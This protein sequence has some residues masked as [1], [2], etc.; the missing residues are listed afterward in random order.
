MPFFM[1]SV[2]TA[3]VLAQTRVIGPSPDTG[4]VYGNYIR[5][6]H[7]KG[8]RTLDHVLIRDVSKTCSGDCLN[9][10]DSSGPVTV[11]GGIWRQAGSPEKIGAI[12]SNI[13]GTLIVDGVTAIGSYDPK[14]Q[15][16]TKFPNKDGIMS[17]QRTFL[18]VNGGRFK[19]FWDAGID[20]KANTTMTGTVTVE[21]SRVSL[22][23]WGP[24]V[25]DTLISRNPRDGH[26]ACL[27]SPV[28]T[29]GIHLRKLVAYDSNPKGLLI[30]FQGS[31]GVVRIDEC[32]LHV[33]ATY[34]V[35]WIKRGSK[36]TKLILGPT[37]A[38]GDKIIVTQPVP[39]APPSARIVD[40]G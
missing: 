38:K 7:S 22:K 27:K 1:P 30:G 29:C 2:L 16:K 28:V 39:T 9:I 32:E 24:L 3:P 20:T 25:G 10:E 6:P 13:N 19:S 8:S 15:P 12:F 4:K 5:A 18:I 11:K 21:N 40:A 37:C 34:R 26:I 23:V 33:P 36:N 35:S 14:L 31:N 17:A